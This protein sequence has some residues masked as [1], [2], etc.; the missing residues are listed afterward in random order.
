MFVYRTD[1]RMSHRHVAETTTAV[2]VAAAGGWGMS[3]SN[4]QIVTPEIYL[5]NFFFSIQLCTSA[6]KWTYAGFS[7]DDD[8]DDDVGIQHMYNVRHIRHIKFLL[9][10]KCAS[11]F[12]S[13]P[14]YA[15]DPYIICTVHA[16]ILRRTSQP[17][18][19]T[20]ERRAKH[21]NRATAAING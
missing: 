13:I 8:D 20:S 10:G 11:G 18:P 7:Y 12:Y 17:T 9:F 19:C 5:K 16:Y 2:A 15:I 4:Q 21:A 6:N 3:I 1:R 14:W